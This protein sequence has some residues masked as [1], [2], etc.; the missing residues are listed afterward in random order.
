MKVGIDTN[1]LVRSFLD[2]GTAQFRAVAQ[3]MRENQIVIAPSV[4]LEAE[5]V[6]RDAFKL[7]REQVADA[8]EALIGAGS[9]TV[10]HD[11][12]AVH[13]L[14][15]FREGCDFADAFHLALSVGVQSF[16]TF[17]KRLARCASSLGLQPPVRLLHH[18]SSKSD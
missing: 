18:T 2:D 6:L 16:M 8:F 14:R 4:L 17:D 13:A 9:V 15:A 10:L 12:A 5:W 7:E 3:L 11:E 1:I